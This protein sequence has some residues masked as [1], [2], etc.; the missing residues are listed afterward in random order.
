MVVNNLLPTKSTS[1]IKSLNTKITTTYDIGNPDPDETG[2]YIYIYI[3]MTRLNL[4]MGSLPSLLD[5]LISNS[6]TDIN[7][8]IWF[9]CAIWLAD[10]LG[11]NFG[12]AW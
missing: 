2:I 10:P 9:E 6:N 5:N 8:L 3:Y 11:E 4:L 1:H 7:N 12:Y